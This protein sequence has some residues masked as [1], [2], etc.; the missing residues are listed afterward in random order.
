MLSGASDR[1][2]GRYLQGLGAAVLVLE[3]VEVGESVVPRQHV[4]Q[5]LDPDVC[6]LPVLP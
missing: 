4:D 3:E 2:T 5:V 6:D 1:R